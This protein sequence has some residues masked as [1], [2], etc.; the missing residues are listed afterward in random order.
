MKSS[1]PKDPETVRL[2]RGSAPI[3][4]T[5]RLSAERKASGQMPTK[6]M[7]IHGSR[8]TTLGL[9]LDAWVHEVESLVGKLR[10]LLAESSPP[11]PVLVKHCSEC[12]F[13]RA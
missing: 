11:D 12:I 5:A 8:H 10:A 2:W 4:R 1:E 6:G 7:I 13:D 9:K 3:P